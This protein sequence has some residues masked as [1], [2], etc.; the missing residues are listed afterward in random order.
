[1]IL[2]KYHTAYDYNFIKLRSRSLQLISLTYPPQVFQNG[3]P[4]D[5][6]NILVTWIFHKSKVN[7]MPKYINIYVKE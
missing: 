6:I 7:F 3:V 5:S 4:K 1:M 2:H